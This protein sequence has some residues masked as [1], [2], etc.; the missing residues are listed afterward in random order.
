MAAEISQQELDRLSVDCRA[1]MEARRSLLLS[2]LAADGMP[3]L[4]YAPYLRD[5]DGSFYIYIS[6]LASHTR[7][8]LQHP[9]A[10][11]LFIR[12]ES[13]SRNLFARERL[14][15][16]CEAVEIDRQG[17]HYRAV[18]A[19]MAQCHGSMITMLR[20]LPDFRLFRLVP[21]SGSYVVGFGRAFEVEPA[22]GALR[23]IDADRLQARAGA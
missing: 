5:D 4:S 21:Q 14:S 17:E 10:G 23:H 3:E 11:V 22:S 6:Q 8:L 20:E 13:E 2:T 16:R 15:F 12:E 9:K 19:R 7:N 18:L 1:L